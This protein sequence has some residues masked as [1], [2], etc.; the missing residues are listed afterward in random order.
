[1]NAEIES[2]ARYLATARVDVIVYGCTTGSF[3]KGPGWDR[4]MCDVIQGAAGGPPG[5]SGPRG[6]GGGGVVRVHRGRGGLPRRGYQSLGRRGA[7]R[8]R[9]PADLG[10]HAVSGLEQPEA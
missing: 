7:P 8:V 9:R 1:M 5:G 10:G 3:F 4:E 2:R 6:G